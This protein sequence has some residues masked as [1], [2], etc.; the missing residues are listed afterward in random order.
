V[1]TIMSMESDIKNFQ[2]LWKRLESFDVQD[3]A[4]SDLKV[5]IS[6]NILTKSNL[7]DAIMFLS[8]LAEKMSVMQQQL[9][10]SFSFF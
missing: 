4:C 6:M 9:W 2:N 3:A 8:S 7:F 10:P 5:H 1:T